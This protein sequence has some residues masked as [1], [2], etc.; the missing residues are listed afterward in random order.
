MGIL[1]TDSTLLDA[2]QSLIAARLRMRDMMP[3]AEMLDKVGFFSL[4]VW[5]GATFDTC[6]RFLNEDPWER[7]KELKDK[8]KK[9]RLQMVLRG[10]SLVGYRHYP[11]DVVREFIRLAVKNGVDVFR[12]SDALNDVRNMKLAIKV[13]N[14][15]GAHVQG[16]ICYTV[17]PVNTIEE[18]AEM[19]GSLERL[20]CDSVCI[21]DMAGLIS[22]WAAS[23]L[24][25][26]INQ[27]VSIPVALHSHCSS[28]M[29]PMSYYAAAQA[30]VDILDTA[31]SA[32]AWG[33][34]LPPTE[35]VVAAFE[36]TPYDTD[37]D[38]SLL[39]EIG[40]F[41]TSLSEKYGSLF[42]PEVAYPRANVLSHQIPGGMLSNLVHQLR[43]QNALDKFDELL[44]EVPKIRADLGYPPMV[45][46]ISQ[47]VVTQAVLNVL[48]GKRYKRVTEELKNYFLGH[49]GRIPSGIN[50]DVRK[51]VVGSEKPID[52][53]PA[54]LLEPELEKLHYAGDKLGIL[55]GEE[56]LL[57]Y[58]L[59]PQLAVKFLRGEAEE[60]ALF[61]GSEAIS[62]S[63]SSAESPIELSV[64]VDGEVFNVKVSPPSVKVPETMGLGVP[65]VS[66]KGAIVSPLRGVVLRLNVKVGDKVKKGAVVAVIEALKMEINVSS[67]G[68]GVVREILVHEGEKLGAGDVLMWVD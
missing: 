21:N 49:Y 11:D 58:A 51:L 37:L 50:E 45:A 39:Y 33:T 14:Q 61:G 22:P 42:T 10:Q 30:G 56:D 12:I 24:V 57:T 44:E 65:V 20:G 4:E 67:S 26:S 6:L 43:S 25:K 27:K 62:S 63:S 31:F 59:F 40:E 1:I 35:S 48:Y 18:F 8:I 64:D 3:I 53:R 60:E 68:A 47:V 55:R 15:E 19:A 9:T 2:Q 28:G 23:E 34:S 66:S 32:F 5:G 38:L 54:E 36:D 46:P 52:V 13:A 29:A 16:T 17:S 7:L 41:F